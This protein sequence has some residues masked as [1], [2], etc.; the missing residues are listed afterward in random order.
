MVFREILVASSL[1]AMLCEPVRSQETCRF[2]HLTIQ[3]LIAD[4]VDVFAG[5][6]QQIEVRFV[7][8]K[9]HGAVEVFPEAPLT[10]RDLR[11]GK[12]CAVDGGVWV[13]NGVY[14]G[15]HGKTLM[16]HEYSGSNAF[17]VFYDTA[18]CRKLS[19][20]VISTKKWT[21]VPTETGTALV[22]ADAI[23]PANSLPIQF[24]SSCLPIL[25]HPS[26]RN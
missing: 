11:S 8:L 24:N 1:L 25:A 20:I 13:R 4:K 2:E 26:A 6:A 5:R 10:I 7:N 23:R 17:L 16:T 9:E 18:T 22:L 14:L 3:P 15:S 12:Q 21:L 19:D